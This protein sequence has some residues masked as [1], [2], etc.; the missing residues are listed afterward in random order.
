MVYF[1]DIP[2]YLENWGFYEFVLPFLLFFAMLYGLLNKTKIFG[3]SSSNDSSVKAINMIIAGTMSFFIVKMTPLGYSLADFLTQQS[4]MMAMFL[5]GI[6]MFMILGGL[7][8]YE[9]DEDTIK[10]IMPSI[11]IGIVVIGMF[12]F[13]YFNYFHFS[14]SSDI[15]SIA[16]FILIIAGVVYVLSKG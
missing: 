11:I 10:T 4:G 16:L 13:A 15:L 7:V 3:D 14:I 5:Y 1:G 6:L 8:G 2:Y 9:F 12:L